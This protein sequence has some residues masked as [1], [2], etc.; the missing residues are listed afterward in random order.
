MR[1]IVSFC[2]RYPSSL[3]KQEEN[4]HPRLKYQILVQIA[5]LIWSPNYLD[6][7]KVCSSYNISK[8]EESLDNNKLQSVEEESNYRYNGGAR[9][10]RDQ[11][12]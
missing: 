9:L 12:E 10:C 3:A 1:F 7:E 4:I 6:E 8:D 2:L 11:L 5:S